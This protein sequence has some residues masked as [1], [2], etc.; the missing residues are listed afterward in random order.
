MTTPNELIDF[1]NREAL[2]AQRYTSR[3]FWERRYHTKRMNILKHLLGEEI[4][5]RCNTFLDIGCGTGEYLT[6]SR[7]YSTEVFGLDLSRKYL[8]RC[9]S[10]NANG[11]V[12]A[13]SRSLPFVDSSFDCVLCSE[14]IEHI[15]E[16]DYSIRETLR[17]TKKFAVFSTPNQGLF[18]RLVSPFARSFIA[19]VDLRVGHVNIRAFDELLER[20][21][22]SR[23]EI[24]CAFTAQVLPPVLDKVHLPRLIEPFAETLE[25]WS[26]H[27]LP[28]FGSISFVVLRRL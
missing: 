19:R 26:D 2:S 22:N 27:F 4:L 15:R 3:E 24:V 20:L 5:G 18:R 28:K 7:Q 23:W 9:K 17:V 10:R 11:L 13:D 14:V 6:F 21:A 16:Q 8:E 1:Y 25:R 12:S